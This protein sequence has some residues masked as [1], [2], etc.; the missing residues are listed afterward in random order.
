MVG[1]GDRQREMLFGGS[2]QD[3]N[4]ICSWI[5]WIS[6]WWRC[7]GGNH[8]TI[9]EI[10]LKSKNTLLPCL[11]IAFRAFNTNTGRLELDLWGL[12]NKYGFTC[13]T[14]N[15]GLESANVDGRTV[16]MWGLDLIWNYLKIVVPTISRQEDTSLD[17]SNYLHHSSPCHAIII[18]IM[19]DLTSLSSSGSKYS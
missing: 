8:P 17:N 15:G 6:W 12:F 4:W 18:A 2:D 19:V 9:L 7:G 10:K 11:Y 5:G 3:L 13:Y 16:I 1:C 14:D